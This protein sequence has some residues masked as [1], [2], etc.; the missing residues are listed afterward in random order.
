MPCLQR[1]VGWL[2]EEMKLYDGGVVDT[3]VMSRCEGEQMCMH[4]DRCARWSCGVRGVEFV[5][6]GKTWKKMEGEWRGTVCLYLVFRVSGQLKAQW[7]L[8]ALNG[9]KSPD[10]GRPHLK[11]RHGDRTAS[12]RSC[13]AG[14]LRATLTPR[15]PQVPGNGD[16]G[17]ASCDV[18][19]PRT[20]S[21]HDTHPIHDGRQ[22]AT[23]PPI[24][25][26][27]P[28]AAETHQLAGQGRHPDSSGGRS[29]QSICFSP[30]CSSPGQ[31]NSRILYLFLFFLNP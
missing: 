2:Q 14:T 27:P 4:G 30:T 17:S 9:Q 20:N 15:T 10:T 3:W 29:L 24:E 23:R 26:G 8:S 1:L 31:G 12:P 21:V 28:T 5:W 6:R 7:R 19:R 11:S 18:S 16:L 22:I 13:H 25:A